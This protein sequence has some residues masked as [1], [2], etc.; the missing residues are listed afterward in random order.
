M[1]L[2]DSV[3]LDNRA[4][5]RLRADFPV[6]NTYAVARQTGLVPAGSQ[7]RISGKPEAFTTQLG[8]QVWAQVTVPRTFCTT[9][10]LQGTSNNGVESRPVRISSLPR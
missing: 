9:V 6:R 3:T 10:F 7:V 1:K 2:G 4:D 5:I 8:D